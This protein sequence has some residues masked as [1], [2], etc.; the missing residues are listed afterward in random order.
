MVLLKG[1][2]AALDCALL[3]LADR[4]LRS[5]WSDRSALRREDVAF[6][7]LLGPRVLE[8]SG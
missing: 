1:V 7:C 4:V 6:G 3:V 5:V 8:I 2:V